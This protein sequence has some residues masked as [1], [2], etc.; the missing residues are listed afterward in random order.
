M[1]I[2]EFE[3]YNNPESRL[4]STSGQQI[5]NNNPS[6]P[7]IFLCVRIL[8]VA[9]PQVA[10]SNPVGRTNKDKGLQR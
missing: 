6:F 1:Q 7:W 8:R 3:I 9:N 4:W 2:G 5:G 10:G